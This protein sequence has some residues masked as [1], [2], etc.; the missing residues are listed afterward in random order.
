MAYSAIRKRS[1]KSGVSYQASVKEKV[2]GRAVSVWTGTY[3]TKGAAQAAA[4]EYLDGV[5]KGTIRHVVEKHTF[6]QFVENVWLPACRVKV[7][8]ANTIKKYEMYFNNHWVETRWFSIV[9]SNL[10]GVMV[11]LMA[12]WLA[13]R[14]F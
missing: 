10:K 8:R 14:V 6:R 7:E 1:L 5:N 9:G 13:C 2:D 12:T 11:C 4:A 3:K